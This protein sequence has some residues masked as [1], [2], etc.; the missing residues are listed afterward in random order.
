MIDIHRYLNTGNIRGLLVVLSGLAGSGK[1]TFSVKLSSLTGLPL[2][3]L[4]NVWWKADRTHITEEEF[5]K[6]LHTI[7]QGEE[8]IIDGDYSRTYEPRLLACDTV[9]FLDLS[10]EECMN[11]IMERVGKAR[12]DIPWTEQQPDPE[13]VELVSRYPADNR[14]ILYDL[15]GKYPDKQL[16]VF[17]TRAQAEAWLSG[18]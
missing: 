15:I 14:P 16:F 11:G 5:D 2:V 7:L 18:I 3:H 13:L 6:R 1:S 9:I 10:A 8:W 17:R 12:A 4:D